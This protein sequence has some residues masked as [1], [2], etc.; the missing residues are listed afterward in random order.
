MVAPRPA[1]A[2]LFA[3]RGRQVRG[4]AISAQR[5]YS[6]YPTATD[7]TPYAMYLAAMSMYN[8]IPDVT[9]DQERA[10]KALVIFQQL[11]EKFPKSEYVEDAKF[12]VQVVRDQLAGKEMSI[13]R[14]YLSRRNNTAAINRFRQVL[15]K[16][17]T[18][19][20]T[21]EALTVWS[22]PIFRWA[23]C[24]RRR[25][26]RPCSATTSRTANGTR[27]LTAV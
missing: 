23:S 4:S 27:T 15:S 20:H 8:Q 18:T 11:I 2:D 1:D 13:G 10:D 16:Y 26:R 24:T 17:Q 9:R 19:R 22:K 5:Y 7:E 6:L 12:K 3:V 25:R 14:F 21:E